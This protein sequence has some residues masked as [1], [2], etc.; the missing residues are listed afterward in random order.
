M[1]VRLAAAGDAA[2]IAALD[3]REY[4]SD[5]R[6]GLIRSAAAEGR[7]HVAEQDDA[8]V[9]FVIMHRHFFGQAFVE[10]LWVD[11]A[12]RRRGI[13]AALLGTC[14]DACGAGK[15][16]TSTNRSNRPMQALLARTGFS[17]CGFVDE[18]DEEDPELIYCCKKKGERI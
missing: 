12:Y 13:G 17:I 15:L 10:L 1:T 18:L 6:A 8:I 16:F 2:A 11:S 4:G 7:C 3:T 9:G 14:K 5:E